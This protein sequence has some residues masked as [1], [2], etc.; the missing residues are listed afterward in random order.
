M[1]PS[2]LCHLARVLLMTDREEEAREQI[3]QAWAIRGEA[4]NYVVPRILF[5]QSVYAIFDGVDFTALVARIRTALDAPG[6]HNDW[7]SVPMID[8]LRSRLL[9]TLEGEPALTLNHE[10]Q[11]TVWVPLHFLSDRE[12]RR[13]FTWIRRG[14]S[15]S[16]TTRFRPTCSN[17]CCTSAP[18]TTM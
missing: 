4:S 12:N 1:M 14:F 8:H 5:F 17:P 3:R 10:V 7:T 13:A 6:S 15:A 18:S 16:G 9:F 11:E 2:T